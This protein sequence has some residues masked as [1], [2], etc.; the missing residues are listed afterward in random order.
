MASALEQL[1]Q[2]A[3]LDGLVRHVDDTCAARDWEHLVEIRND[4]RAAVNTGRQLWPIATLAN[5]RLALWAPAPFA[6]RALDDTARTFMPGPVSEILAVHHSWQDLE[7]LLEPG[8]D[9]GLCAYERALRG[10]IIA[11]NEPDILDIPIAL[12]PWEPAYLCVSYNDD[13]VVEE[14]PASPQWQEGFD[15]EGIAT[16]PLDESET[17]DAFRRMMNAWTSQS[18]GT[19]DLAIVEGGPAEALGALGYAGIISELSPMSCSEAWERLTWAASTGGAHGKRRGVA[20]A[21]SD[22][23]WLFAQI[24][25]MTDDWPCDAA[26]CGE[27]ALACEYYVFR[28]DKT[29]TEGWGLHLVIV[30]PDEGLSVALRAHDSL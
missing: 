25:G 13:G 26:E 14:F 24:A 10:D 30:D 12:Q 22:V 11:P 17:I 7:P 8:H 16:T 4:A 9:R 15:V 28:N 5:Y 18:N 21:R 20:T 29:P 6:V 2:R 19:A 3:D 23:W 1:I 27:I